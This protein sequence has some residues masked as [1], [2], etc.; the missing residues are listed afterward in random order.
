MNQEDHSEE[1][2]DQIATHEMATQLM[3]NKI[4]QLGKEGD[5]EKVAA[6][7]EQEGRLTEEMKKE[8]EGASTADEITN[9]SYN[10][11]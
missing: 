10:F 2:S 3:E 7:L 9:K 1:Y 5:K 4:E 11:V 8:L 6:Y